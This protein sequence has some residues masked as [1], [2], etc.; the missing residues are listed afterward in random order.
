MAALYR[1]A[2][3]WVGDVIPF[4]DGDDAVLFYLHVH[5]TAGVG[6]P[7][8]VIR[9]QDFVEFDDRG[10]AIASG[11][12]RAVDFNAY[13]GSVVVHEGRHHLFYTGHNPERVDDATGE[14]LQLVCHAV[15]DDGMATWTKLPN[16]TFGAPEG[17]ERC[18]WRDP[19]VFRPESDG[20]WRML[21]AA[22][23]DGG[24]TRRRGLI[25][26][27]VSDDLT[28]W[29]VVEPFWDPG[30][31]VAHECPEVFQIGAWWY[32]VYS[33]C[34]E[35][36]ATRYRMSRTPFGPWSVP[37][38]D[39]FDGRA[40]YA[41]KTL[42]VGGRRFAVGWIPTREGSTDDGPWQFAGDMAVHEV[43]QKSDGT[44]GFSLPTSIKDAFG[45]ARGAQV[46]PVTGGWT[47]EGR[48][49]SA[50]VPDGWAV[51]V[52]ETLPPTCVVSVDIDVTLGARA[53]G[54]V[55]RSSADGDEGYFVRLEPSRQ[56][57][58]FDRWPRLRTGPTQWQISGD[59]PHLVE[60]ERFARIQ[61]GRHHLDVLIDGSACVV[62]LDHDVAMSA[63]IYDRPTGRLGLFVQEGA[64]AFDNLTISAP[65]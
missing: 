36:F 11:G 58:T 30:L 14:A 33:E 61:P 8:D 20:P 19:F 35:Q 6:T 31:Y 64:G 43:H 7:W 5:R 39:S 27:C 9:T 4:A 45:R 1:P 62:Y 44:L 22:R 23:R 17:Y 50:N 48:L 29:R 56:R 16:D 18:D 53:I 38:L 51:A 37:E 46:R 49:L 57:M 54:I 40:F 25:A 21:L 52:G 42:L 3:G 47:D 65:D 26:Q 28:T 10:T 55:L 59:V 41:A 63:R 24:P 13:T 15:S 34:S 2:T 60:L 32:L 12:P